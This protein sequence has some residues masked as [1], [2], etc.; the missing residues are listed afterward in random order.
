MDVLRVTDE[1]TAAEIAEAIAHVLA[2]M[3]RLPGVVSYQE[4]GH[5]RLNAL[6]EDYEV[7]VLRE[8]MA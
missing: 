3:R 5:A 1:T 8:S 7:A 4:R 2:T 6:L